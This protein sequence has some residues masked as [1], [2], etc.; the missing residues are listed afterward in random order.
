MLKILLIDDDPN[1]EILWSKYLEKHGVEADISQAY[2]LEDAQSK[3]DKELFYDLWV[4]DHRLPAM[5]GL[6]F[7]NKQQRIKPF[8]Y[9]TF[10][11]DDDVLTFVKAKGGVPLDKNR[12]T[13]HSSE[14]E[15]SLQTLGVIP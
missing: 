2:D 6:E 3:I 8:I 9:S 1:M 4:V 11:F 5:T 12:L 10:Y 15:K 14:M 7:L 13:H